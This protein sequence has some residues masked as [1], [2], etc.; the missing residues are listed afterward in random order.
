M[1]RRRD[2][3][4]VVGDPPDHLLVHRRL[5]R[6]PAA[7]PAPV[8][9]ARVVTLVR[10]Y[11][12]TPQVVALANLVSQAASAATTGDP[13]RGV[14][15]RPPASS[16][17]PSPAGP[18]PPCG[19]TRRPSEACR[20]GGSARLVEEGSPGVEIA[21]LFR[22]N[23]QSEAF[24]AALARPDVPYLVRGGERFFARRRCRASS[25]CEGR[26][27]ADGRRSRCPTSSATCSAVPGGPRAAQA[28]APSASAGSR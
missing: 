19:C 25:C 22:T 18:N 5:A 6:P 12:S 23:A 28:V 3:V 14:T 20:R 10:N 7:I 15:H 4:C 24:E 26:P 21:V 2:D 1:A 27:R 8:P 17:S 16:S 11:R 13:T 9:G